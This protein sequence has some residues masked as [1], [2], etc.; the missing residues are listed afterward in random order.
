METAIAIVTAVKAFID[1][2]MKAIEAGEMDVEELRKKPIEYF[3]TKAGA[4]LEAQKEAES[5]LPD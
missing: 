1:F 3:V 2:I 5:H 4:A